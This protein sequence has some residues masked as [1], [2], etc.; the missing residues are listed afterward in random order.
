M[1]PLRSVINNHYITVF[2]PADADELNQPEPPAFMVQALRPETRRGHTRPAEIRA[3]SPDGLHR[4]RL[5]L[6][7]LPVAGPFTIVGIWY[8]GPQRFRTFSNYNSPLLRG[9]MLRE[10]RAAEGAQ[11]PLAAPRGLDDPRVFEHWH[12]S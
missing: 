10:Y 3:T 5:L 2:R 9:G 1:F 8:Y 6:L 11:P 4:L 7:R 12:A